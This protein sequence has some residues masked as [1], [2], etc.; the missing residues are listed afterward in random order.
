MKNKKF[1]WL[2]L[3]FFSICI[4]MVFT[5]SECEGTAEEEVNTHIEF[6]SPVE[7][8]FQGHGRLDNISYINIQINRN[9]NE[10]DINLGVSDTS[11]DLEYHFYHDILYGSSATNNSLTTLKISNIL[12]LSEDINQITLYAQAPG[13]TVYTTFYL[14][15]QY[16]SLNLSANTIDIE[17]E[18]QG[19]VSVGLTPI[20]NFNCNVELD[21]EGLPSDVYGY[22]N[23]SIPQIGLN[24]TASAPR[25]KCPLFQS[26]LGC[27]LCR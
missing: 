7:E 24:Q 13:Q 5:A 27:S 8:S 11:P 1:T 2:S 9:D 23:P 16:F 6:I 20:N 4:L 3:P 14:A 12:S 17:Q 10:Q 21:C 19:V 15:K 22:W 26:S 25:H 18:E